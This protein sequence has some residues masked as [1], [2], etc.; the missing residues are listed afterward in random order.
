ML[1]R[2]SARTHTVR[3]V[4]SRNTDSESKTEK[5]SIVASLFFFPLFL[6]L[7]QHQTTDRPRR[8][9]WCIQR[10]EELRFRGRHEMDQ[11]DLTERKT[12]K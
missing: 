10:A 5:P 7:E 12:V 4:D 2:R 8:S 3:A 11:R 6:F 9:G 1:N